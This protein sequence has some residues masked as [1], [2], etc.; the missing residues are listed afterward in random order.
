MPKS[1]RIILAVILVAVV[2]G[3]FAAVEFM[4][5]QT[6]WPGMSLNNLTRLE[7]VAE[8]TQGSA[9]LGCRVCDWLFGGVSCVFAGSFFRCR[10]FCS[11]RRC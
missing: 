9:P 6:L 11:A 1:R 3:G 7:V 8:G 4:L 5:R 10:F 2:G